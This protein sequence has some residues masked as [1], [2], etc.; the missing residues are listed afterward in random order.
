M[1]DTG[2]LQAAEC[3]GKILLMDDDETIRSSITKLLEAFGYKVET[4][5]EGWGVLRLYEKA[6]KENS[7]FDAVILDL[8]V[9]EGLGGKKTIKE[10]LAIDPDV[11]GIIS[12]GFTSNS[13]I[14]NYQEYGFAGIIEK[15]YRIE[16]LDE[17]LMQVI[18]RKP[19]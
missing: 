15:P 5:S 10:L 18:G 16:K 7:R 4:C 8:K 3:K 2:K 11:K 14:G 17:L 12:T 1:E 6:L 13:L 19:V 9:T